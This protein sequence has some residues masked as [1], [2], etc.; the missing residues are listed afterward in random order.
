MDRLTDFDDG[1]VTKYLMAREGALRKIRSQ[2]TSTANTCRDIW[3]AV[4]SAS[5]I[6][7][8]SQFVPINAP[9][10]PQQGP[11]HTSPS[12]QD[13]HRDCSGISRSIGFTPDES[14]A[15]RVRTLDE[16]EMF[17]G[18]ED[19]PYPSGDQAGDELDDSKMD[20]GDQLNNWM[21]GRG[22]SDANICPYGRNCTMKGY[23][24]VTGEMKVFLLNSA[25][26]DHMKKHAK[27]YVCTK[28]GT[29]FARKAA[30]QRHQNTPLHQ[31]GGQPPTVKF[32]QANKDY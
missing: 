12:P 29:R 4:P 15:I 32:V 8:V 30:L 20:D 28:C 2:L 25:F 14:V 6:K 24:P 1:S 21:K 17:E 18:V 31:S 23:D 19:Y 27:P 26:N 13:V 3:T 16:P 10:S 11:S 9:L 5:S 22:K 7:T